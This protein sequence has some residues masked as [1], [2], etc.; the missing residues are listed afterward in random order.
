M[1]R[2]A[3]SALLLC[4]LAV[5]ALADD[6]PV[7]REPNKYPVLDAIEARRAETAAVLDSLRTLVRDRQAAE[8]T[9]AEALERDLRVDWSGCKLPASP[10]AFEISNAHLPPV[11]QFYTGSCWA[12]AATSLMESEV[13]RLQGREIK[14]SEMWLVYW[15][16][17]EKVRRWVHVYGESVV[18]EGSQS[19]AILA[20]YPLYGAVPASAYPGVLF[21]DGRHDHHALVEELNGWLDWAKA[22]D[23]WDEQRV[24]D[25]VRSILDAHLGAP[26]ATVDWQ[27]T[28]LSPRDFLAQV[29]RLDMGDYVSCVSRMERPGVAFGATMLLDVRDNWRRRAEYL[30]LP[31][32]D[33]I[34]VVHKG[35]A[36]GYTFVFGGDNSEPGLDGLMDAA[37]IP[38]WDIPGKSI[39]QGS[40]EHRI[41]SRQTTDDHGVHV[42]GYTRYKGR[43]WY[44]V[45]DSNR[46]SRLGRYKGYYFFDG[47]YL[48]LKMLSC[49]I[50]RDA[51]AVIGR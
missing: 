39:D 26:P 32:D 41:V 45:K 48:K 24:L 12:F 5:G 8:T 6:G 49:L 15:E 17:V 42:V 13:I 38:A 19:D 21:G 23:V 9:A 34:E 43:D 3:L 7:Y 28:A 25:G 27:G 22:H 11:A 50:H 44:L 20:I 10:A 29:L 14:L 31:L 33:L 47:D 37:V 18:D 30:N 35:V 46:S 4:C 2:A 16:Y 40:R 51:L 36:N 1:S